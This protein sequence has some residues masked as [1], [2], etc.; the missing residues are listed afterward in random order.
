MEIVRNL[1]RRGKDLI[2]EGM[3]TGY[4][5]KIMESSSTTTMRDSEKDPK[6]EG[7]KVGWAKTKSGNKGAKSRKRESSK[8][9]LALMEVKIGPTEKPNVSQG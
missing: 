9:T 5:E 1:N 4:Q 8:K 2:K 3:S 7:F 6:F